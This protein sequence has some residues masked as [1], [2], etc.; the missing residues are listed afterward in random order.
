VLGRDGRGIDHASDRR[1]IQDCRC[2]FFWFDFWRKEWE[3]TEKRNAQREDHGWEEVEVLGSFIA[4]GGVLEDAEAAG[5]S[6]EEVEPL[7]V[8]DV[9]TSK[10]PNEGHE[11]KPT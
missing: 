10:T 9:S 6:C 3:P 5:A 7:P 2:Q 4:D 11:G 8:G 1:D